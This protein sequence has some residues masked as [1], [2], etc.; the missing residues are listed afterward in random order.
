MENRARNRSGDQ[1]ISYSLFFTRMADGRTKIEADMYRARDNRLYCRRG[2]EIESQTFDR[3]I[4]ALSRGS[5]VID[6][7]SVPAK[8]KGCIK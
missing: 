8:K 7:K 5:I 6:Q 3:V 1:T 4:D 2:I